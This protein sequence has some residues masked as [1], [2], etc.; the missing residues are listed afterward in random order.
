[1][2]PMGLPSKWTSRNGAFPAVRLQGIVEE[3]SQGRL[4]ADI[5]EGNS[6]GLCKPSF[7]LLV[8]RFEAAGGVTVSVPYIFQPLGG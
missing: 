5:R 4:Q 7:L 6:V 2:M 8:R 3:R 1:M